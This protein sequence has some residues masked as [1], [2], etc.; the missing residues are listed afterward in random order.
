MIDKFTL[1]THK[2]LNPVITRDFR[3]QSSYNL[4]GLIITRHFRL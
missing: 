3:L 4:P 2:L 1:F